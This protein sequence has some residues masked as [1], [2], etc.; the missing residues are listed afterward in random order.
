MF[1]IAKTDFGRPDCPGI[2]DSF[3]ISK[4]PNRGD[5]VIESVLDRGDF[6]GLRP[7]YVLISMRRKGD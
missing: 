5:Y 2:G 7:G 6:P 1:L 4:G 3:R